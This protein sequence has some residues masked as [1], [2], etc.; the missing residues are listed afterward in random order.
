MMQRPI[1]LACRSAAALSLLLPALALA[2]PDLGATQKQPL[3]WHAIGLVFAVVGVA[4]FALGAPAVGLV[5]TG[6]ALFAAFLNAAFDVCL[7]C[8]LYPLAV[9]LRAQGVRS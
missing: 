4:G 7:G 1:S 3:N 9:R 2:A 5:A 8:L 6:F